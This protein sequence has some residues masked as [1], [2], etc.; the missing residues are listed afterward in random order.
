VTRSLSIRQ[1]AVLGLVVVLCL[2]T[3][4]WGLF[5]VSAKSGLWSDACELT[6]VSADAQNVE[7]GTP[8]R[9]RG[10]EYGRVTA[11][12]PA[13]NDVHIKVRLD[14]KARELLYADATARV[15]SKGMLGVSVV[16]V[17]AG[18]PK[19]GPLA[20]DTV[21]MEP[22]P[23]LA[24]VTARLS[25]V[26]GRVDAILKEVQEGDG[27]LPKL[28]KDDAIY[29]DLKAASADTQKLVKN[30]NETTTALRGDAQKTLK[31]VN[32]SVDSVRNEL[33]GVKTF[34]RSGQEAV[35][36][37]KQ[38]AEAIK[39]MPIVRSYVEDHVSTLVRPDSEKDRVVYVPEALFQTGTSVLTEE[40][41]ARLNECAAWLNGQHQKNSEVVVAAFADPKSPDLTA[42]AARL[43]TKKQA[44]AVA[45]YFKERGVHKM[46]YVTRRKVT[47]V[48]HGSDPSPV[49]EKDPLPA[50]RIEVIL[51]WPR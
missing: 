35:T 14:S 26:A 11:V 29:K 32:E 40:G 13:G 28:L 10:I 23:D 4:V 39:S 3:G 25:A 48:G 24:E 38:D 49:V 1:A 22:T 2:A 19:A 44:E 50:D 45:E 34:V 47:P 36:A 8:V 7:P 41:K 12:E 21:P 17:K 9:V 46:G 18:T 51:F 31:G 5:R 6:I 20:A 15:Q 16:D 27:T 33:D 43:L 42:P 37:I 30:L